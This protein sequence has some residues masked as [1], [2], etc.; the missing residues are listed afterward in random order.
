MSRRIRTAAEY[1]RPPLA[2]LRTEDYMN[3]RPHWSYSQLSQYLRCPLQYFF[4]RVAKLPKPFVSS[5]LVL[6]GSVHEALAAYHRGIESG[7]ATTEEK[8]RQQFIDAWKKRES[9]VAIHFGKGETAGR[10]IEQ[11]AALLEAYLAEPP[12]E[13]IMAVEQEF[14]VP[15][16][17]SR[18]EFLEKPLLAIVELECIDDDHLTVV[19]IKSS[20]RRYGVGHADHSLQS[21]A[22]RHAIQTRYD[23][24]VA[25]RYTVLIKTKPPAVQHLEAATSEKDSARLGDLVQT[26]ELAIK[27]GVNYPNES[28]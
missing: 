27:A 10:L 7:A 25:V 12:P 11:G 14:I 28:T 19:E 24:P 1:L 22:Y 3:H 13:R 17:N 5:S 4:E 6:G 20:Q 8:I 15:L 23:F 21:I 9:E 26:V 18:G 2:G 16:Q